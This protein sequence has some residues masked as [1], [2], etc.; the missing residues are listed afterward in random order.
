MLIYSDSFV[1]FLFLCFLL[2]IICLSF[3]CYYDL[4]LCFVVFRMNRHFDFLEC[5]YFVRDSRWFSKGLLRRSLMLS[6]FSLRLNSL[7]ILLSEC[8]KGHHCFNIN[9]FSFRIYF[10][11]SLIDYFA[12]E[13][14]RRYIKHHRNLDLMTIIYFVN[15]WYPQFWNGFHSTEYWIY[16]IGVWNIALFILISNF[17]Y[18]KV[19]QFTIYLFFQFGFGC[20]SPFKIK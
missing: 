15:L 20:F 17:V 2:L 8:L 12:F 10:F 5:S 18:L 9:L 14:S 6:F 1:W 3:L 19:Y 7:K 16:F 13:F 11:S 4:V